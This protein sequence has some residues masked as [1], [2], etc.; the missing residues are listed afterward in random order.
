MIEAGAPY[1]VQKENT[2][3]HHS[4]STDNI[5]DREIIPHLLYRLSDKGF[6]PEA[7]PELVEDI[8]KMVI[9]G[10]DFSTG[11]INQGL[12]HRGWTASMDAA[13]IELVL[14]LLELK[15]EYEVRCYDLH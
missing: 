14:R 10:G 13:T 15:G 6:A 1:P 9:D 5:P 11:E 3:N 2:M 12:K 4:L 8:L 7:I